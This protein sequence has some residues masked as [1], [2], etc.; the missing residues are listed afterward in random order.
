MKNTNRKIGMIVGCAVLM[1]AALVFAQDWPQWRGPDR[2]G[3]TSGFNAPA[4][5]PKELTE[6]WKVEVGLGDATPALVGDKL[7]VFA[8]QG[9]DEVALCLNAADGKEIWRNK[10]PVNVKVSG[11]AS[12]HSGPRSS[13]TVAGG[14]V[15]TLAW[16][17][18]FPAWTPRPARKFGTR[19]IYPKYCQS[20]SLRCRLSS[21]MG[22]ASRN[23]AGKKKGP[24]WLLT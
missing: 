14:K 16:A 6:K 3:K 8:R 17:G 5:W 7:Y 23:W 21:S 24:L 9:D 13:P 11:G 2:D 12:G 19:M 4:T 1:G 18:F 10:Y 22:C 15:I 20:F